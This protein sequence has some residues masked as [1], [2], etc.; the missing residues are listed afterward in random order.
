MNDAPDVRDRE[1]PTARRVVSPA[2]FAV[3]VVCFF[4][5]FVTIACNEQGAGLAEGLEDLGAT[6]QPGAAQELER[7]FTGWHLV[8]GNTDEDEAAAPPA[9]GLPGQQP[10]GRVRD[11]QPI[12]IASL[13]V[14]VLGIALSWLALWIGPVAGATLGI[15]GVILLFVL[16]S[17]IEGIVPGGQFQLFVDFRWELGFW[18]A[19]VAFALAAAWSIYRLLS[20]ARLRTRR[21]GA[22]PAPPPTADRDAITPPPPPE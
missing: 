21:A 7:T 16:K 1:A 14:A 4:L 5:P 19:M 22:E 17:N 3:V 11:S 12:A 10:T 2:L 9:E 18:L 8:T 6:P 13:A 15:A 20:E